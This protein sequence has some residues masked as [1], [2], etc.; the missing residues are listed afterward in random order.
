MTCPLS[1]LGA[2]A[3]IG[4]AP[5]IP[6]PISAHGVSAEDAELFWTDGTD[7]RS[8]ELGIHSVTPAYADPCE[9]REALLAELIFAARDLAQQNILGKLE[10]GDSGPSMLSW[11]R[12]CQ[13][14]EHL[15]QLLHGDTCRTGRV[16]RIV[17][18]LVATLPAEPAESKVAPGEGLRLS[19]GKLQRGARSD[20]G[21]YGEPW[22]YK[23]MVA[24]G[25]H[26]VTSE[27]YFVASLHGAAQEQLDHAERI[28]AC[29]N[30]CAGI[31]TEILLNQKPLVSETRDINQVIAV[32]RLLPGVMKLRTSQGVAL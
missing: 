18:A 22:H 7:A 32:G 30:F 24:G 17:D 27:G 14:T 28:V 2:P 5:V 6:S 21:E 1:S 26:V 11:C 31:P 19:G 10:Y 25:A 3:E 8:T 12:E 9:R 29:V 15:G 13:W 23:E 20:G 4:R 16:Q